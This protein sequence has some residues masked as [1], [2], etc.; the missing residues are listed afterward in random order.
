M[1]IARENATLICTN[2]RHLSK[3]GTLDDIVA[4]TV[5]ITDIRYNADVNEVRREVFK[6]N[7]PTST[8]VQVV[9]LARPELLL[10]V[11]AIAV[12]PRPS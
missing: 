10:E 8:M 12:V 4:M 1:R 6:T 7:G 5:F 11:N 2:V 3:G 9:A